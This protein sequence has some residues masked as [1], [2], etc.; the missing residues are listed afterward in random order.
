MLLHVAYGDL[1]GEAASLAI[2]QDGKLLAEQVPAA[3]DGRWSL[4][5]TLAPGALLAAVATQADGDYA[6]YGA[7]ASAAAGRSRTMAAPEEGGTTT[8]MGLGHR[9]RAHHILPTTSMAACLRPWQHWNP[10][11]ARRAGRPAQ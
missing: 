7:P 3:P 1:G 11:T 10:P 6:D 2:W 5:V 9:R 4:A 8:R